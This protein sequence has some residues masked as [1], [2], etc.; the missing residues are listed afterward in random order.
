MMIGVQVMLIIRRIS[1]NV[2]E[3]EEKDDDCGNDEDVDDG[4]DEDGD[5][6]GDD[7]DDGNGEDGDC[8]NGNVKPS[9]VGA[10]CAS[11]K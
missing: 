7:D 3:E 4:N 5:D 10:A 2:N 6:S 8:D 9:N 1:G 11:V